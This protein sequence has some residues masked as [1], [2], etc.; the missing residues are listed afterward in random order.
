MP[1]SESAVPG[2]PDLGLLAAVEL[3]ETQQQLLDAMHRQALD[4]ER[5][6]IA[7]E[8]HDSV[9]QIV[10]SYHEGRQVVSKKQRITGTPSGLAKEVV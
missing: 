10:L 2:V 5:H 3:A 9:A 6:R 7:R 1:A 4:D 8:L